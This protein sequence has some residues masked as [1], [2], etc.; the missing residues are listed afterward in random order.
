MYIS[1]SNSTSNSNSNVMQLQVAIALDIVTF[2][3]SS[4][5]L[6]GVLLPAYYDSKLKR[7]MH[8]RCKPCVIAHFDDTTR[9]E[10]LQSNLVCQF[11]PFV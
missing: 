2:W 4:D 8:R 1:N 11:I 9:N 3:G 5:A 10:W 6:L 7:Y